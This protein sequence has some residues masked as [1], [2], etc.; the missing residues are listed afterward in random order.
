[1]S[2]A[3]TT[4]GLAKRISLDYFKRAHPLRSLRHKLSFAA[5]G[6]ALGVVL[7]AI[8]ATITG[9]PGPAA[10]FVS[11]GRFRGACFHRRRLRALSWPGLRGSILL[12]STMTAASAVMK[13]GGTA[14]GRSSR[15]PARIAMPS[16]AAPSSRPERATPPAP[17]ATVRSRSARES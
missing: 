9:R 4:K 14:S 12:K 11:P 5:A 2:R 8:V 13:A 6:T 16:T 17:D 10:K 1:M 7:L 15:R 3:R